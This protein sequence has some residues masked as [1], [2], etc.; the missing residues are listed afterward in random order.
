MTESVSDM[1]APSVSVVIPLYNKG[2]YIERA[3]SSILAQTF[4]PLEIIVID[5]GST[6]DGP[7]KVRNFNEPRVSLIRQ[8]NKGPGAARNAG[9]A[10][11][12]GK[13]V[14]FLDAD[15]EWL[16]SFLEAG[17]GRL[18]D[19]TANIAAAFIGFYYYPGMRRYAEGRGAEPGGV[20]EISPES[21]L[22]SVQ[23]ICSHW[24]CA[25]VI[26]TDVVRKWGGFFDRYKCLFGED[27]FLFI[28]LVFN[29][30]IGIIPEPH[31]IYHTEASDLYGGG[32]ASKCFPVPPYLE[33]PK[34]LLDTCPPAKLP[35]LK[36]MLAQRALLKAETMA[37]LGRGR[38]ARELLNRFN[39]D[40]FP[41]PKE[42]FKV[43]LFAGIAPVLPG[44]GWLWRNTKAVIHLRRVQG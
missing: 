41:C 27:V 13:Y 37:R 21:D 20:I 36:K 39:Q 6:D 5:D 32:T 38:E 34:E 12:R 31:A 14:S 42:V 40:G 11:A 1:H 10:I 9:L 28:K 35:I 33:D 3:M 23:E 18:E 44:V 7:E 26:R 30:R 15:D 17:I 19:V 29:E 22:E 24:T 25:A 8:E 43:R 2:R 16:P 4:S